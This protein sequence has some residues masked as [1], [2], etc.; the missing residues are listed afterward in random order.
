MKLIDHADLH[1]IALRVFEAAGSEAEEARIIADHLIEANL[2]GHD[3]HGV[4]M[5]PSYL[6]NLG[7]GTVVPTARGASSAR[8]AR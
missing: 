2:R 4:G 6:R 3:S 5:I 7:N 1:G 8:T